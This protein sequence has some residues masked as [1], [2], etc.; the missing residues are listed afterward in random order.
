[1][2][3]DVRESL[4]TRLGP[5]P[6][7]AWGL[8][9][10]G[11]IL[12]VT[13]WR[14]RARGG[15]AEPGADGTAAPSTDD[16]SIVTTAPEIDPWDAATGA[17][18]SPMGGGTWATAPLPSSSAPTSTAPQTNDEWRKL[19]TDWL[20]SEGFAPT[21]AADAV[22]K[23]LDGS[24][25]NDKEHAAITAVLRE[26][27][28]PPAGAPSI[29][30]LPN[31]PVTPPPAAKR[32]PSIPVGL[33]VYNVTRTSAALSWSPPSAPG[34][35]PVR[36][37][38]VETS[39]DGGRT[40][41]GFAVTKSPVTLSGARVSPDGKVPTRVLITARSAHGNSSKASTVFTTSKPPAPAPTPKP[42]APKPPPPAPKPPPKPAP[43]PTPPP[44]PKPTVHT[45][46]SGDV[47][48]NLVQRYYGRVT[49]TAVR[50]VAAV[51]GIRLTGSG[52][53]VRPSPW[54]I[55]QRVTFPPKASVPF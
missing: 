2:A 28:A 17:R 29:I 6:A 26:L 43:K 14:R 27:R 55:G 1:M 49:M 30:R 33:A 15:D 13:A 34:T 19:A 46:R 10:G 45:I 23:Y 18:P 16:D 20:I 35:S 42:T 21:L 12:G 31:P 37:Y 39:I 25:L 52:T 50:H 41:K 24:G 5:L 38:W 36:D 51:N 9:L 11:A 7:W 54:R 4:S 47:L 44:A 40:F 32:P 48:W 53:N 8:G 3:I 22:S